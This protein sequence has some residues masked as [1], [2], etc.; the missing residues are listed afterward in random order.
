MWVT[1]KRG[2]VSMTQDPVFV[3]GP[4]VFLNLLYAGV[5]AW[6]SQV[7][8]SLS[9]EGWGLALPLLVIGTLAIAA[10]VRALAL[11][12]A[13]PC[14]ASLLRW[15]IRTPV[16]F[17]N[18]GLNLFL[19]LGSAALPILLAG[20]LAYWLT[21]HGAITLGVAVQGLGVVAGLMLYAI[22]SAALA[23]TLAESLFGRYGGLL[24]L[25]LAARQFTM[26][27]LGTLGLLVVGWLSTTMGSLTLLFGPPGHG[28]ADLILLHRWLEQRDKKLAAEAGVSR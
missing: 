2:W 28:Y 5:V 17:L 27:P 10:P 18:W 20:A 19:R 26:D 9:A 16:F 14:Q 3:L 25:P 21:A 1:L 23:Y 24:A 12:A 13:H 8:V 11:F 7:G 22:V 4:Y 15:G 6:V